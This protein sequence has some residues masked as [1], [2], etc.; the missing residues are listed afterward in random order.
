MEVQTDM[1]KPK[2]LVVGSFVMDTISTTE[3]FPK[4]GQ[5]VLGCRYTT[6]PGGKGANQAVE[7]ALL[8]ADVTMVGKVGQDAFGDR[9]IGSLKDAGA[10]VSHVL[11]AED[12]ISSAVGNVI[13]QTK[14]GE[15]VNNRIIVIP[16]AN[17]EITPEDVVF[18]K[19]GVAD[20]DMVIL[21]LEIPMEINQIVAEY[22]YRKG[23]PVMLNPAP[24]A[25]LPDDLLRHITY[26]SPNETEAAGL[27]GV[28]I[29]R[30][31]D[32]TLEDGVAE[33]VSKA[34]KA[35][36]LQKL[37][38]TLGDQGAMVI[39]GDRVTRRDSVKGIHAVDPTAAGDSF[40]GAF[41]VARCAG[42]DDGNA[43]EFSNMIGARTV[44]FMGA[45]P[46]LSTLDQAIEFHREAGRDTRIL[47][48]M[49]EALS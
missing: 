37:L 25:P 22:A 14:N 23:V 10:D 48:R 24:I 18:L 32:G 7:A 29:R 2:I 20:F 31:Q 19:E 44:S 38:V 33:D 9:L 3:V 30:K 35:K 26:L 36:G 28:E 49:K 39:E 40:V 46:S 13:I 21:Q 34:M 17:M 8:G 4:E 47:E 1:K 6:A 27:L 11:R 41:C 45:Q 43:L 12:G 16:G 15:A 5:T 42:F